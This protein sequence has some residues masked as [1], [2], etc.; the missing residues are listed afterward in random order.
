MPLRH[1]RG[2]A[3]ARDGR[4]PAR[5]RRGDAR[6]KLEVFGDLEGGLVLGETDP[7]KRGVRPGRS[8]AVEEYRLQVNQGTIALAV[9]FEHGG[10]LLARRAE[11]RRIDRQGRGV[12][13]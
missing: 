13:R 7:H 5:V 9:S 1:A 11:Y 3:L 8:L 10:Y 2:R 4:C 6:F 12:R